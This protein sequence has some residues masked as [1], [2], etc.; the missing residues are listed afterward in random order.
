LTKLLLDPIRTETFILVSNSSPHCHADLSSLADILHLKTFHPSASSSIFFRPLVVHVLV[1][2]VPCAHFAITFPIG[3]RAVEKMQEALVSFRVA[4]TE[5][6][7]EAAT[8]DGTTVPSVEDNWVEPWLEF[9]G[10]WRD[11]VQCVC[12][13]PFSCFPLTFLRT[14][15]LRHPA[16]VVRSD[17]SLARF[18]PGLYR[19]PLYQSID[20]ADGI[21]FPSRNQDDQLRPH[22]SL[23]RLGDF[24]VY[25][26]S[27]THCRRH[28]RRGW[29]RDSSFRGADGEP[30]RKRLCFVR[31]TLPLL[32]KT[33]P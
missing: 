27:R 18:R 1:I 2:S 33:R 10:Q 32:L 28:L 5:V 20:Q 26:R 13:L 9:V 19:H 25:R 23:A 6:A 30:R 16:V 17:L 14:Q 3:Y 21:A 24:G 22:S 11:Y 29:F 4:V 12:F 15:S 8:W 7:A 31:T